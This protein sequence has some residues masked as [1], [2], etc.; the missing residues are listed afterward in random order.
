MSRVR[1][2]TPSKHS[3][4]RSHGPQLCRGNPASG[5]ARLP[6]RNQS[7]RR[8]HRH[9]HPAG[10]GGLPRVRKRA[11]RS[12]KPPISVSVYH[13]HALRTSIH[14]CPFVSVRPRTHQHGRFRHVLEMQ[15]RVRRSS[16]SAVPFSDKFVPRM[17]T[18]INTY[19][20]L[21]RAD[22]RRSNCRDNPPSCRRQHNCHQG[23]RWLS[24]GLRRVERGS[25][26]PTT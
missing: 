19:R 4:P 20:S 3:V 9:A 23:H 16:G 2:G 22:R 12:S 1:A 25:G 10:C 21:G 5:R 24:P 14:C 7:A 6:H 17:R 26:A 13:L 8:T 18:L 11:L 15:S